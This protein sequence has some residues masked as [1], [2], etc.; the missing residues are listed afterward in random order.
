[1]RSVLLALLLSNYALSD[2]P[3]L[4]SVA[5]AQLELTDAHIA[6]AKTGLDAIRSNK[7]KF[8]PSLKSPNYDEKSDTFW[9]TSRQDRTER[10]KAA[11]GKIV[12]AKR[13]RWNGEFETPKLEFREFV[14]GALGNPVVFEKSLPVGDTGGA[15]SGSFEV[16]SASAA[17]YFARESSPTVMN[18][19]YARV[20]QVWD[21][22]EVLAEL[23]YPVLGGN[24]TLSNAIITH[25]DAKLQRDGETFALPM[26]YVVGNRDYPSKAGKRT[27]FELSMDADLAKKF[28][29]AAKSIKLPEKEN[30]IWKDSKGQFS[31]E[32]HLVDFKTNKVYLE[33][34]D[35]TKMEL[36]IHNLCD[37]DRDFVEKALG[38]K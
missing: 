26:V 11:E 3:K 9:F 32:A 30:R 25:V 35:G 6:A 1:M 18:A 22:N 23:F 4:E 20:I 34:P 21:N 13:K 37:A 10:I 27:V 19:I 38:S 2:E 5:R 12:E 14:V 7:A 24:K 17:K 29:D 16:G 31:V 15:L 36:A 33:K 28:A 8:N